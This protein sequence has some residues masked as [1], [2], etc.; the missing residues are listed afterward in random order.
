M[1]DCHV[2]VF[3]PFDRYPLDPNRLYTPARADCDAL[4]V[5]LAHV[6]AARVTIVQPSPYASDHRCLLAALERLG[7]RARGIAAWQPDAA[8]PAHRAIVG[9]RV[10]VRATADPLAS[11]AL[12][13]R[14]AA[15]A[16]RHLEVQG[17]APPLDTYADA[18]ARLACPIVLDHLAGLGGRNDSPAALDA[19]ARLLDTGRVWV[20]YSAPYRA[21]GML[22]HF[23][24]RARWIHARHSE[25]LM[26][27]SDW[28]HTPSHPANAAA[29]MQ[30]S[31][32]RQED[33]RA[34]RAEMLAPFETAA[35]AAITGA[36]AALLYGERS[37]NGI[38]TRR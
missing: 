22:A 11:L 2:H 10:H 15:D 1:W 25:R 28:P 6:D 29:R 16:G 32:F 13:G 26:W 12:A 8:P 38:A 36:N 9:L 3:G 30:P 23:V 14:A 7:S 37:E 33:A 18:L 24:E 21:S 20:K 17:G 5:H 19:L 34:S 35:R 31:A 4:E 27:G